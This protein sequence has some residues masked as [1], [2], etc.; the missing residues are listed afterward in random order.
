ME[1]YANM[2]TDKT[3]KEQK[4]GYKTININN[5]NYDEGLNSSNEDPNLRNTKNKF[6]TMTDYETFRSNI[7]S[8]KREA[9]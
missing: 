8:Y 4:K 1:K 3:P 6:S 9:C 5:N 7:L 2:I